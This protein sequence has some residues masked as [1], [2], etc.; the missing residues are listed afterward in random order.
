[1]SRSSHAVAK[2]SNGCLAPAKLAERTFKLILCNL[3][4]PEL[5]GL[6]LISVHP[7][8]ARCS[9]E[10]RSNLRRKALHGLEQAINRETGKIAAKILYP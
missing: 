5:D 8:L 4:M 1:M 2:A 10:L 9:H 7:L 3:L 6:P